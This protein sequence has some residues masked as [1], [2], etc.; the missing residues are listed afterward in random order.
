MS[1]DHTIYHAQNQCSCTGLERLIR[2]QTCPNGHIIRVY[3]D[4]FRQYRAVAFKTPA[5]KVGYAGMAWDIL[6][7]LR[8][9]EACPAMRHCPGYAAMLAVMESLKIVVYDA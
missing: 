8:Y 9:K 3:R 5:H 6:G 2:A 1:F 4:N 7:Q